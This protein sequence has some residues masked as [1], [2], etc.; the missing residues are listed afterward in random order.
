MIDSILIETGKKILLDSLE[1]SQEIC[2]KYLA[3]VEN[4][5]QEECRQKIRNFVEQADPL[6]WVRV[7][8]QQRLNRQALMWQEDSIVEELHMIFESATTTICEKYSMALHFHGIQIWQDGPGYSISEHLD[9]PVI[10]VALQ[11]YLFGAPKD[12]GTSFKLPDGRWYEVDFLEN[13]GY[14]LFNSHTHGIKHKST[15]AVPD[16]SLRYSV[17]GTWSL[18]PK[19]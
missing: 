14:L 12:V 15:N 3:S 18:Q 1:K 16:G 7:P 10:N 17:Y 6:M 4:C 19:R 8:G 2:G 11:I 9:N 13:T 5:L